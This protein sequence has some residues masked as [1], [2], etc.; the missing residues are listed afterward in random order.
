MFGI[1]H[2][3]RNGLVHSASFFVCGNKM[4]I[5]ETLLLVGS[6]HLKEVWWGAWWRIV[7][8]T[9]P[10]KLACIGIRVLCQVPPSSVVVRWGEGILDCEIWAGYMLSLLLRRF[11]ACSWWR[12]GLQKTGSWFGN[13]T[14]LL[15]ILGLSISVVA[16]WAVVSSTVC[17]KFSSQCL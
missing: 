13:A 17:L 15:V 9:L 12:L 10:P 1:F 3:M 6:W 16:S 11:S 5:P 14:A 7:M 8:S 4:E 2:A